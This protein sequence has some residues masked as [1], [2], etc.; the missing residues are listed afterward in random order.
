MI[1]WQKN[2][3]IYSVLIWQAMTFVRLFNADNSLLLPLANETPARTAYSGGGIH[4]NSSRKLYYLSEQCAHPIRPNTDYA[5]G[6]LQ[7]AFE[8][9]EVR[10]QVCWELRGICN[11]RQIG[12]PA[13]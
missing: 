5:N 9:S 12:V 6:D 3:R 7:L 11:V 13:G 4:W 8:E 10:K 2:Y 1:L